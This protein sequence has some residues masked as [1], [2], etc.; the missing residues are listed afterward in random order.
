MLDLPF[1]EPRHAELVAR[2]RRFADEEVAPLAEEADRGDVTDVGRELVRRMARGGLF[3]ELVPDAA[4]PLRLP[5]LRSVCL[6][7]EILGA[8]SGTAD[9]IFAVQGL[10][11]YPVARHWRSADAAS[12]LAGVVR[13]DEVGAFALTEPEAG[14]DAGAI[15]TSAVRDKDAYILDGTKC[16]ISNAGIATFYVTF[17]RTDPAAG[18]KGLSAFVVPAAS[19]G[20]S[21]DAPTALMAPHPIGTLRFE[22]CRVPASHLLGEVGRGLRVA[23]GTLDF[24]R[25]S[26]G[27]AACG[28][29]A[30]ALAD[31]T[32]HAQTRR[33]F[34]A[35][36]AEFQ[37]TKF[38]LADTA[39]GLDAA[40]LLVYRAAWHKDHGA[41][42][43]TRDSSMAKLYA[44]EMAQAA[45]DR[46]LQIHGGRGV[47]KGVAVERLYREI[48]A[49]RIYEGT[50]EIQRLVIGDATL[51]SP[52]PC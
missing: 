27:A 30:R 51:A 42:R 25:T 21:V 52:P 12:L 4:D 46:A 35:F 5:D 14:S 10:G 17:A 11:S 50:S 8:R 40:R 47:V 31:A 26:V 3:A 45:I 7:R 37:A 22:R 13:G 48:R 23:L 32:A 28:M 2:V 20:L 39:T 38:A 9:A 41:E 43:I 24:F 34:N 33:Q 1:F 44:T 19:P 6:V 49:L 16:F 29:A 18:G 36:L 15:T